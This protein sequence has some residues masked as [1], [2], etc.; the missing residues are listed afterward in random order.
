MTEERLSQSLRS[1]AVGAVVLSDRALGILLEKH[2][3]AYHFFIRLTEEE[4]QAALPGLEG[5]HL[6]E[7]FPDF[8][9]F[10]DKLYIL[11]PD[12]VEVSPG[13]L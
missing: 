13:M 11:L 4:L 6:A 5:Y 9:Q 3:S 8:G 2:H 12:D 7:V 10:R 1:E